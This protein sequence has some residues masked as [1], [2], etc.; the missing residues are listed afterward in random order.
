M[1]WL[2]IRLLRPLLLGIAA[3]DTEGFLYIMNALGDFV[4]VRNAS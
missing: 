1:D 2:I 4:V 3:E